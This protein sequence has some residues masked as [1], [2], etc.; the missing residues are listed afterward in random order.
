MELL[1]DF[2]FLR[3]WLLLLLLPALALIVAIRL[4]PRGNSAWRKVIDPELLQ[5]LL[6][7]ENETSQ[8]RLLTLLATGWLLACLALAG[9]AWQK[10]ET[11]VHSSLDP[12]VIVLDLS[13]GMYATDVKPNRLGRARFKIHD[14]LRQRPDGY[15]ALVAYSGDAHI[16]SPLT[17][18]SRTI[19]NLLDALAPEVM[20]T[21]GNRPSTGVREAIE[22]LQ[23]GAGSYGQILLLTGGMDHE[24]S[25]TIKRLI[26]NSGASL[27]ILGLGTSE[28]APVTLPDGQLLKDRRGNIM[29][30][31]LEASEL[32]QL[33]SS[34][35]GKFQTL[36]VTDA[37]ITALLD[38]K[39]HADQTRETLQQFDQWQDNGWMLVLPLLL[40]ALTGFRRG[41][42][43]VALLVILPPDPAL[44]APWDDFS[45]QNLWQT[46]DQQ[47][48]EALQ[49][50][51]P[52]QAASLFENPLW[53]GE[54]AKQHGDYESAAQAFEK[55]GSASGFYNQGNALAH[56][57]KLDESLAAYNKALELDPE[58]ENARFNRDLVEQM[59]RQQ[60]Q[61]QEQQKQNQQQNGDKNQQGDQN[62]EN[63][64]SEQN[65]SNNSES[66][67]SDSQQNKD[68]SRSEQQ[69]GQ[70]Q[71]QN[72]SSADN[73]SGEDKSQS[74][75]SSNNQDNEDADDMPQQQTGKSSDQQEEQNDQQSGMAQNNEEQ[76]GQ[77]EAENSMMSQ[78]MTMD[79]SPL[80]TEEQQA[81]E[82]WLRKIPD[83][84]GGLLR[85]KF[86]L[87]HQQRQER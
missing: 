61:Q 58:L 84:P 60:E 5:P 41:W 8:Q 15:T 28:G 59:K 10:I 16:A 83:D 17:D 39:S 75:Q 18:D 32:Q 55:A 56:A 52:E 45:W 49:A 36:A 74:A 2:H 64:E 82:Q 43:L 21:T 19:A 31:K 14:I 42:L 23:Q 13:P 24:E 27:S 33:A 25:D 71:Q 81:M 34:T 68:A 57:G 53:R 66:E 37:D 9:P 80:T 77:D 50:D 46:P 7:A 79:E 11:P 30:P 73:N 51:N 69:Q 26:N 38:V 1:T 76:S 86:M 40:L 48:Q 65:Q 44:A 85:R 6:Q 54:A 4:Q 72:S 12:L 3:P 22:L 35:G 70:D 63:S 29:I 20:P 78:N 87:E 67:N 47:G 62:S